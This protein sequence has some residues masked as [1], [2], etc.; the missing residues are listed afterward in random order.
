M[1]GKSRRTGQ[2]GK[3]GPLKNLPRG[4]S[5]FSVEWA[6]VIFNP[7]ADHHGTVEVRAWLSQRLNSATDRGDRHHA[8]AEKA[9]GG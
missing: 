6:Y 8:I 4:S 9:K 1:V 3:S 5:L 7:P 2:F